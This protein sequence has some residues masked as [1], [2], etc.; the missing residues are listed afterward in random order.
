MVWAVS[1]DMRAAS[2]TGK[3]FVAGQTAGTTSAAFNLV[4]SS[5]RAPNIELIAITGTTSC[6]NVNCA[7]IG[8]GAYGYSDYETRIYTNNLKIT[9][10]AVALG[11]AVVSSG[12]TNPV[13]I[14]LCD[15]HLAVGLAVVWELISRVITRQ[16]H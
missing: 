11:G 13:T 14:S 1:I 6:A 12:V 4:G 10:N 15:A 3:I 7:G 2:S 5:M 16:V 8:L 9:A